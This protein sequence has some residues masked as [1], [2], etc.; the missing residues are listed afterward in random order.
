MPPKKDKGK[1]NPEPPKPKGLTNVRSWLNITKPN[2]PIKIEDASSSSNK[3]PKPSK[4]HP[5]NLP[6]ESPMFAPSGVDPNMVAAIV[7]ALSQSNSSVE[8]PDSILGLPPTTAGNQVKL[9]NIQITEVTSAPSSSQAIVPL[10]PNVIKAKFVEKQISK[11]I[12][13]VEKDFRN[14]VPHEYASQIFSEKF[15]H[16]PYDCFKTNDFYQKI[17]SETNSVSFK[18]FLTEGKIAYSTA[19]IH[20][21]IN[22]GDWSEHPS[23]PI[24]FTDAPFS[25][26]PSNRN[27]YNCFDYKQAWW[28]AFYLLY[29]KAKK[30]HT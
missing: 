19:K 8:R 2:Q 29:S 27:Q 14:M 1:A 13:N 12:F 4:N 25:T 10:K 18:H 15:N 16:L 23:N 28:N 30:S 24:K 7:A 17:L 5:D 6:S 22:I 11:F 3:P 21:V 26:L 9:P 20:K